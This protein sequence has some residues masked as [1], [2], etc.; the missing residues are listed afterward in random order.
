ML[1]R[2]VFKRALGILLLSLTLPAGGG[3]ERVT[4]AANLTEVVL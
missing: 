4:Y 1:R 2:V 3:W